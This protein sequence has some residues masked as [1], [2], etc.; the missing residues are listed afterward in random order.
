MRIETFTFQAAMGAYRALK[1][2]LIEVRA[3]LELTESISVREQ[4]Y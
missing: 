2:L 4:L 3:R 1:E